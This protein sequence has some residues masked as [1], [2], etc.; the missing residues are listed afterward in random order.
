MPFSNVPVEI[1][2]AIQAATRIGLVGHVTP[3]ADCLGS[4]AALWLALPELGHHPC[5][6]VPE[7]TVSRRLSFLLRHAGLTAAP[8][9]ELDAC[10]LVI[11]VDT[12]KERRVN[13]EG[14]WE[15]LLA[16]PLLNIDHHSTNTRFGKWN[17]VNSHAASSCEMV[18]E[19]LRAL[20][21]Q[22]TPTIAT[23]LFAGLHTDTQG[24]S[25]AS[26]T[27]HTLAIA[28]DL[29]GAG[30][31]ISEVCERL[32]RSQSKPEFDLVKVIYANTRV[33][34]DGRLAW[35][36]ASYDEITAAGCTAGDIENQVEIPRSIEGISA[37]ILFSEGHPR[38]IRIN[39][40]GE[41]TVPILNLAQQFG[42]GGHIHS[43]G[44]MLDGDLRE[45]E[46][47]IVEAATRFLSDLPRV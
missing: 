3:D 4:I 30:A 21:C 16:K 6:F 2:N 18:Y 26:T 43:A 24:F 19:L 11:V 7:S 40:R 38:K 35:S 9:G 22:V 32:H 10:D 37:A 44:A 8:A 33:T 20:N 14:K 15:S 31:R 29:A 23:L 1:C 36:S 13:L 41:G 45:I 47:R 42:G 39:F 12:A 5:A 28:H 46:S 34:P 25:L 17:W 27:A